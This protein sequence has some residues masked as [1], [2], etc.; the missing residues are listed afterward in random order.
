MFNLSLIHDRA[1]FTD[2]TDL[3]SDYGAYAARE[4]AARAERSREAGNVLHFCRWRQAERAVAMV[5]GD[6]PAG[7]LH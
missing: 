3:I 2:A 6:Q 4:A 7:T 1:A 5:A